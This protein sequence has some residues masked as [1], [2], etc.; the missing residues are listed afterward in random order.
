[1]APEATRKSF[2]I[3]PNLFYSNLGK[4]FQLPEFQA[5]IF[6]KRNWLG[7]S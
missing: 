1:M 2:Q 7:G 6:F 5:K 3:K 4:V